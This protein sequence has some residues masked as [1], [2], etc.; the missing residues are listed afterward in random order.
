MDKAIFKARLG[1]HHLEKYFDLLAPYLRDSI[2]LYLTPL[3]ENELKIGQTK[4]GG[5]PD[6][7]KGMPWPS[8]TKTETVREGKFLFFSKE[9][10]RITKVPLSFIAQINF[11]EVSSLDEEGL[12]PRA[13]FLYFFYCTDQEAWGFDIRDKD[14]FKVI[15][16]E[17]EVEKL[18]RLDFPEDLEAY[19]RFQPCS[20]E[21]KQEFSLPA[22]GADLYDRFSDEERDTFFEKVYE[23]G[24][25]NKLL[26][27][28]NTIQGE[29][30]LEC[31]L[32]TNGLYCG[33]PSGYHDP[34]AK[35]L[36]PN[37]VHWR[38]LL[39][40]DSN[41]ECG[42]TWGDVG[43]LYYWIKIDDLRNKRFDKSW[44]ILQC[45]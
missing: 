32:V 38:L 5:R 45:C 11:S 41:E 26:G 30:E 16:C 10:Q 4:I 35:E 20:I 24:N 27:Y 7:P 28:P 44:L 3:H 9:N 37:A 12:L 42:M 17:G 33:D 43:R 25:M 15:F 2:R 19:Y 14:K 34:R 40:I 36:E 6:L 29:M 23:D 22:S 21:A 18:H 1:S 13:G 8:E 31:E 39:Q